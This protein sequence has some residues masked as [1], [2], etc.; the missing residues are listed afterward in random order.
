LSSDARLQHRGKRLQPD[1]NR[2]R[3]LLDSAASS[4]RQFAGIVQLWRF[5]DT[6]LSV[7]ASDASIHSYDVVRPGHFSTPQ[8]LQSTAC[9]FLDQRSPPFQLCNGISIPIE[10]TLQIFHFDLK[11][12]VVPLFSNSLLPPPSNF[13]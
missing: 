9:C 10:L 7:Q 1:W 11:M 3:L 13:S 4:R 8:R 12:A 2:A 5:L 6:E